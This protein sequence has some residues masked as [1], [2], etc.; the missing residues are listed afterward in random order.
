M[1]VLPIFRPLIIALCCALYLAQATTVSAQV[2][3]PTQQGCVNALNKAG[4]KVGATQ[5]KDITS[6]IKDDG[7]GKLIGNYQGNRC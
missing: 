2:L 6:C 7:N 5:G 3:S 4:Q 1:H